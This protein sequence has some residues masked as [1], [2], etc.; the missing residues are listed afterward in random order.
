MSSLQRRFGLATDLTPFICH[1][2][3]LI[4]HLLSFIRVMCPAHF[5][6]VLVTYWTMFAFTFTFHLSRRLADLWGTTV[7]F[8]TNSLHSLF[9]SAFRSVM[10]HSRP[11]HSLMLSTHRFLCLPLR[12]PHRLV[13]LV[14][15]RPSRERKVPG[16]NPACGRIFSGSSHTSDLNIGTPVAT[17]P[18]AWRYRVSAGTG[19]PGVSIL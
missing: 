6:L 1:S 18:G 9:F 4:V 16:S 11:V 17:L 14:V 10:F 19:Q 15:R 3:L 12:L 2:V 5:H 7:E 13:G 8:T